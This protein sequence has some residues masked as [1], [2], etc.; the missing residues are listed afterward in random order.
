[1]I[2]KAVYPGSFDPITLGHIDIIQRASRIFDKLFVLVAQSESKQYLFSTEER[3]DMARSC[4][5]SL[6]NVK[7]EEWDGLTVDFVKKQGASIIVRGLRSSSDFD[8]EWTISQTNKGLNS[9][10]ET[11]FMC[12]KPEVSFIASRIVKEV[13][14]HGG[15]LKHLVPTLIQKKLQEKLS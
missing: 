15:D 2:K 9:K 11:L 8:Q 6:K 14:T 1:M 7:V 4:L 5:K 10:I 3:V 12:S 13:A